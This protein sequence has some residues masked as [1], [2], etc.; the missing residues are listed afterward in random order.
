MTVSI[1]PVWK[2]ACHKKDNDYKGCDGG[3]G[4]TTRTVF[5]DNQIPWGIK[6]IY[7]DPTLTA[8]SGGANVDVAVLDTGIFKDHLDLSSRVAQCVDFSGRKLNEKRC[9]DRNGHGTHTAGSVLADSGSDGKGIYGVAPQANLLA[10]KVCGNSGLCFTDDIAAAIDYAGSHDA[11]IVSM[12]I[13]GDTESSLVRDA[14]ARNPGLLFVAAAGN[15]GP[16]LGSIDYPGANANVIAVG[17]IDDT[18]TVVDFSSRGINNGDGEI[19][20]KEVEFAAPRRHSGVNLE[21]RAV[22]GP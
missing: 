7:N 15:D 22:T 4:D 19:D 3:G 2:L 10:Y 18:L 9:D 1:V 6:A 20:D 5:P 16:S 14:I 21:R 11:E 12:S 17:A 13:G 8:A